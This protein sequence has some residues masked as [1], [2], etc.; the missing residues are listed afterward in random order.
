MTASGFRVTGLKPSQWF[1]HRRSHVGPSMIKHT[2][3]STLTNAS[4]KFHPPS[5]RRDVRLLHIADWTHRPP[6]SAQTT[7]PAPSSGSWL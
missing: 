6:S 7:P 2:H 5:P 4:T 1:V 3:K